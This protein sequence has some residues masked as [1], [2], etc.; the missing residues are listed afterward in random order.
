MEEV[1]ARLMY[2]LHGFQNGNKWNMFHG[3]LGYFQKTTSW[4]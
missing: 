2:S 3:H 1:D 4:R